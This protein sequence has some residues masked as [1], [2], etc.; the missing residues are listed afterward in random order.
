MTTTNILPNTTGVLNHLGQPLPLS[1]IH[2][3]AKKWD[4]KTPFLKHS[5]SKE[6]A[7]PFVVTVPHAGLLVPDNLNEVLKVL[8]VNSFSF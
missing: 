1:T 7:L 2:Y 6:N 3:G 4:G 8:T 5:P